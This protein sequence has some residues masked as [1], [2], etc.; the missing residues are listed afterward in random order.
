MFLQEGTSNSALEWKYRWDW[1]CQPNLNTDQLSSF[2]FTG[3]WFYGQFHTTCGALVP[4]LLCSPVDLLVCLVASSA[5]SL[6]VNLWHAGQTSAVLPLSHA[7]DLTKA[8]HWHWT[9]LEVW[10][11]FFVT[12]RARPEKTPSPSQAGLVLEWVSDPSLCLS[13]ARTCF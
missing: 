8:L 10:C 12:G 1:R 11:Y 13:W 4:P 9:Q 6:L 5:Q 2:P 3:N 7:A